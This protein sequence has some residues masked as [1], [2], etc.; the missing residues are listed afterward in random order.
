MADETGR[1][2]AALLD[3]RA[4]AL[5]RMG[6]RGWL[7]GG[8]LRDALLGLP[9]RD[10]DLAVTCAPL[11]LARAM[12]RGRALT[13]ARLSR[14]TVRLGLRGEDGE[15][16]L[17]LDVAPL[18]GGAIESDLALRDFRVNALALPLEARREFFALLEASEN[19]PRQDMLPEPDNLLDPL[20]GYSD[21][22]QRVLATTTSKALYD[23]PGRIIRAARLVA[24]HGFV[25]SRGL[26]IEARAAAHQ[27]VMLPADRVGDEMSA[28][29]RSTRAAEGLEALA[30][31]SALSVLPRLTTGPRME[32]AL[33][34]VRAVAGMQDGGEAFPGMEA[35]ASLEPLRAWYASALPDGLPRIVALR[36]GLLAHAAAFHSVR[37]DECADDDEAG[38][39]HIIERLPLAKVERTVVAQVIHA[40][41]WQE[42]LAERRPDETRMR[43]FFAAAGDAAIDVIVAAAACNAALAFAPVEGQHFSPA[44]AERAREVVEVYFTDRERLVP[45]RLLSGG[46]LIRELGMAPGPAVGRVLRAVRDAQIQGKVR[47]RAEA[48]EWARALSGLR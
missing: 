23:D 15:S 47:T 40:G 13:V 4:E 30:D 14:D 42:V 31:M 28:L 24:T 45:P 26:I 32:H 1:C 37:E 6:E 11:D 17:Q 2:W 22:Q 20:G 8:C 35:L 44:V 12:R 46:D 39:L 48:L 16:A 27:L 29:L 3:S 43:R 9:V 33:A 38:A 25:V 41:R 5:E 19:Q 21:L 7:V 34:S 18:H 36:W 10:L